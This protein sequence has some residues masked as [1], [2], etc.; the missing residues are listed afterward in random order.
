MRYGSRRVSKEGG[1]GWDEEGRGGTER[2]RRW[3]FKKPFLLRME[4][5]GGDEMRLEGTMK[6]EKD[7]LETSSKLVASQDV[8]CQVMIPA[9]TI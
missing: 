2:R 6:G 8:L 9:F 3:K 1:N 5:A 7:L 4:V